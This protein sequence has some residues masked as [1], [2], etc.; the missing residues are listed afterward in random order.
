MKFLRFVLLLIL[1]GAL[2]L[3]A[4]AVASS[5]Y[6]RLRYPEVQDTDGLYDIGLVFMVGF[7]VALVAESVAALV[8]FNRRRR[9][10]A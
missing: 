6:R 3:V 10:K 5:I 4:A 9:C 8:L 2:P 1:A 7:G